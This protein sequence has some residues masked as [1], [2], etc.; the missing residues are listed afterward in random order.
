VRDESVVGTRGISGLADEVAGVDLGSSSH[1][2]RRGDRHLHR[3][4]LGD[5]DAVAALALGALPE[6][7][8]VS[9]TGQRL[10]RTTVEL[11]VDRCATRASRCTRCSRNVIYD[12]QSRD[13]LARLSIRLA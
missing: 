10:R 6:H 9:N 1:I 3:A 8:G 7:R 5:V 12:P 13:A 11:M 2:G 4:E